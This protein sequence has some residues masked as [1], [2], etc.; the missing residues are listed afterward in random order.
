M[1]SLVVGNWKLYVNSVAEGKKLLKEI[2][3]KF[4]RGVKST[5]AVCPQVPIAAA[6]R[7]EYG[8]R[9]IAFGTQD[10]SADL[11]GAHTG[12]ASALAL[13]SSG[14]AY[15]IVG[16]AEMR[17]LGDTD[18]IVSKKAVAALAAKL[19][20]VICVGEPARDTEGTHF[21]F[22]SKN[23]SQSLARIE[24]A[25]AARITVAYDPVWAIGQKEAP[26]P[27]V[28]SEAV[29]FIRKTLAGMWGR[30]A[31]LKV[32]I[33]YGGSVLPESAAEFATNS[34]AQGLL[35]GRASVD[36]E[37]FAGIIKAFS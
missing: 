7:A 31:A 25:D 12:S 11:E 23:V 16:H 21:S 27:R 28:V 29:I 35:V 18:E 10:V 1:K 9:R 6:L 26:S 22:L 2:D 17:A 5:V 33:I 15:V 32:R 37:S 34:A 24:P 20:P 36:A 4:P 19:H 8:G 14:L 13:A 3:R 30:D